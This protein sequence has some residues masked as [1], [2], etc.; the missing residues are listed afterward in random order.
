MNKFILHNNDLLREDRFSLKIN[1]RSFLYSDGFFESI[2]VIN[3]RC[4]NLEAHF[5]RITKTS[6]FFKMEISFS[7]SELQ[8]LLNIFIEKNKIVGGMIRMVFY[9]DSEG[10]YFP[11]ENKI[12]FVAE[13]EI[14]LNGFNLNKSGLNLGIFTDIRKD[15]RKFSNYKNTNAVISV[16]ASIYAKENNWHDCLLINTD[17]EIIESSNSNLFIV[18]GHRIITPP[19]TDGCLD[20]TMR[21][22]VKKQ[23]DVEEESISKED[24]FTADEVFLTNAIKGVRWVK[25]FNEKKYQTHKV[26]RLVFDKLN[27]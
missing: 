26:A 6:E 21:S 7:L 24:L 18:K 5:N 3:S 12:C 16:L 10:K 1:N 14:S 17:D 4:F 25:S 15:K 8:N 22:F 2:K 11:K 9:R 23:F 27:T 19:I 13:T 20:G